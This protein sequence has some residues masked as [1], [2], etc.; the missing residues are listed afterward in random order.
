MKPFGCNFWMGFWRNG[1]SKDKTELVTKP[2]TLKV[3]PEGLPEVLLYTEGQA[4]PKYMGAGP[5]QLLQVYAHYK[6]LPLPNF[7]K[8]FSP[9]QKPVWI[10]S[11]WVTHNYFWLFD[12]RA[13]WH[14]TPI[15]LHQK[16]TNPIEHIFGKFREW[17][18]PN[19]QQGAGALWPL[20]E[21]VVNQPATVGASTRKAAVPTAQ[22]AP[23]PTPVP[24]QKRY[25][26]GPDLSLS[27]KTGKICKD[28]AA[29]YL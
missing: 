13:L 6:K 2:V 10:F 25:T 7:I 8:F 22:T 20:W 4:W 18:Y 9:K 15:F 16:Q 17:V 1:G 27:W 12:C 14:E 11:F 3:G 19:F 21:P 28:I 23:S 26:T 5:D 29:I 24:A